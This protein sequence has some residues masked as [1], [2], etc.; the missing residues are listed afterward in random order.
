[1]AS[2]A[3]AS[4]WSTSPVGSRDDAAA[5]NGSWPGASEAGR[6]AGTAAGQLPALLALATGGQ[7]E[8]GLPVLELG[9]GSGHSEPPPGGLGAELRGPAGSLVRGVRPRG[10]AGG[11]SELADAALG[12][13]AGHVEG[14]GSSAREP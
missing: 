14:S 5:G 4:R 10:T 1:M 11:Q 6:L 12:V 3:V 7:L 8:P 2:N 13:A 9:A